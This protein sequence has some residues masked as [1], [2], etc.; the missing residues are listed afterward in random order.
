MGAVLARV[1]MTKYHRLEGFTGIS[2]LAV[3]E[4]GRSRSVYQQGQILVWALPAYG[5]RS[6]CLHVTECSGAS[7]YKDTNPVGPELYSFD[8]T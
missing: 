6:S 3:L 1:A 8:L 2:S 4:A 5:P 7:S